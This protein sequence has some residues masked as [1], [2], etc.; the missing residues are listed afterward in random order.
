[1]IRDNREPLPEDP[2]S[3]REIVHENI[4]FLLAG[5]LFLLLGTFALVMALAT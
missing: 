3:P 2:E 1:M 5:A 4:L